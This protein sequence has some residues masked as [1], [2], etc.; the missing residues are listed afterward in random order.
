MDEFINYFKKINQALKDTEKTDQSKQ[1]IEKVKLSAELINKYREKYK[2]VDLEVLSNLDQLKEA[3]KE[4]K[5]DCPDEQAIEIEKRLGNPES[6]ET[7]RQERWAEIIRCTNCNSQNV[8]RL[9]L[10]EQI[11]I[12]NYKYLCLDCD[13][14]FDDTSGSPFESG[15]PPLR[16]W[17]FCWYL[18]GCTDSLQYIANKLGLS[19]AVI[20]R[21]VLQM[22][23]LFGQQQPLNNFSSF[24]EWLEQ[25][26]S[27]K[28]KKVLTSFIKKQQELLTGFSTTQGQDT[29]EIRRQKDRRSDPTNIRPHKPKI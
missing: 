22:Q 2:N 21:M 18:L 15:T 7:L 25:N 16:A 13:H 17:M 3:T 10:S 27:S 11:N 29:A 24:E 19:I 12:Y 23:K 14:Q 4:P 6:H 28:E 9:S 5:S 1:E 26:S 8:R 20:E